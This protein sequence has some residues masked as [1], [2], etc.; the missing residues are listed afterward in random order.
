LSITCQLFWIGYIAALFFFADALMAFATRKN[1]KNLSTAL[2]LVLTCG[3]N[4][5][6]FI[7]HT[8]WLVGSLKDV[9][10]AFFWRTSLQAPAHQQFTLL[11]FINKNLGKWWLFNPIVIF[12]AILG[13][14]AV[15][16][17]KKSDPSSSIKKRIAF[18]LLFPPLLFI[19]LLP[20]LVYWHDFLVIYFAFFLA[21]ISVDFLFRKTERMPGKK[22][23]STQRAYL[24][25]LV[26]F[27]VFGLFNHPEEKTIDRNTDNYELYYLMKSVR[28]ITSNQD[29]FLFSIDRIQEPQVRFYLRR[30]SV[31]LKFER[32]AKAYIE[33]GA[34]THYIVENK[35]QF[36]SLLKYLL[37][38]YRGYKYDRY[39]LFFLT[40]PNPS[41]RIFRRQKE[42]TGLLFKY[43]VSPYHQP[44]TFREFTS[45]KT[46]QNV[47]SMF[48]NVKDLY[49]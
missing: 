46:T 23:I 6:L 20:H 18:L 26:V 39:F 35:P 42:E 37:Q 4:I 10:N 2:A 16:A 11:E 29:K 14:W 21:L 31:F 7:L 5:A 24:L 22:R 19:F 17:P 49:Q 25:A 1:K 38:N 33:T 36:G 43:F 34:Y 47:Y 48:K 41:L 13:T 45:E 30:E 9:V 40:R 8:L 3:I 15:L 27:A 28:H 44:G 32:H 12:L